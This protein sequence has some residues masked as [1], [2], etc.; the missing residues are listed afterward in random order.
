MDMTLG[1]YLYFAC[2]RFL[3]T[4]HFLHEFVESNFEVHKSTLM[5]P[6]LG[7]A[8]LNQIPFCFYYLFMD[9]TLG[10]YLYHAR[11]FPFH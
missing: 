9:L 8:L 10:D 7:M 3:S 4:I 11:I 6:F 5:G 1:N 2:I